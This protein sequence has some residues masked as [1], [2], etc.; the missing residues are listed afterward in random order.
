MTAPKQGTFDVGDV[1]EHKPGQ[2][3]PWGYALDRDTGGVMH[4]FPTWDLYQHY[5]TS[6][7]PCGP[8]DSGIVVVHKSFDGRERYEQGLARPH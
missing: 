5:A 8:L 7:C 4:Q 6:D 3:P 1:R 2:L